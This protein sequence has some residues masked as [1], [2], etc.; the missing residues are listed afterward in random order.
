MT[1]LECEKKLLSLAEH[2][3][4]WIAFLA[5]SAITILMNSLY[6]GVAI[7]S[8]RQGGLIALLLG[9]LY[10]ALYVLLTVLYVRR[11]RAKEEGVIEA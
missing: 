4:F 3:P 5:A 7:G 2:T 8:V 11:T 10:L 6:I 1:R 9:F